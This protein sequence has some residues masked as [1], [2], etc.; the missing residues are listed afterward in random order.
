MTLN[1]LLLTQ[2]VFKY[3]IPAALLAPSPTYEQT[4]IYVLNHSFS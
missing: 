1:K 2:C 4:V 3:F